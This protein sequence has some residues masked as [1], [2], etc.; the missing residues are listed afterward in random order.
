MTAAV[1]SEVVAEPARSRVNL[2]E[3]TVE[4][5]KLYRRTTHIRSAD[6]GSIDN[7]EGR[8]SNVICEAV[9]TIHAMSWSLTNDKYNVERTRDV[10]TSWWHS[11]S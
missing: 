10:S 5:N 3:C 1:N 6:R 7:I 8:T 9:Q 4:T 2:K 11:E